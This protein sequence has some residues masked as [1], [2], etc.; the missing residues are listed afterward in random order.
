[1]VTLAK[2]PERILVSGQG[3]RVGGDVGRTGPLGEPGHFPFVLG[4]GDLRFQG[5]NPAYIDNEFG[6]GFR[7][8]EH[9]SLVFGKRAALARGLSNDPLNEETLGLSLRG[10]HDRRLTD[11][12]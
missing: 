3:S 11:R 9:P 2:N 12:A 1:M 7:K 5:A 6:V 4:V 10:E 8:A